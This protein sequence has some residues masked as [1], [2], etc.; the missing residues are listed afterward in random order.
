MAKPV[1]VFPQRKVHVELGQSVQGEPGGVAA[2]LSLEEDR[3]EGRG[4]NDITT[5]RGG[6]GGGES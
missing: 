3:G 6:G 2:I 1:H 5:T 4:G